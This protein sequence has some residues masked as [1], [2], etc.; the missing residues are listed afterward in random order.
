LIPVQEVQGLLQIFQGLEW[1]ALTLSAD[2][3]KLQMACRQ[4]A[5]IYHLLLLS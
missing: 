2:Q 1:W 4:W 5:L 3:T